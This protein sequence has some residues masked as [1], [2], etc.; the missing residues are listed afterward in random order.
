MKYMKQISIASACWLI[1]FILDSVIELFQVTTSGTKETMF[2]LKIINKMTTHE[3]NTVF[4][5]T[6]KSLIFYLTFILIWLV[7]YSF[8][9]RNKD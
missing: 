9:V 7:I 1:V 8:I 5:L 2:G 4:S 3:L 6:F